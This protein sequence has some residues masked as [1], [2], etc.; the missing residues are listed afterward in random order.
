MARKTS[1]GKFI[2]S[3]AEVGSF[4]MCPE[5]WRLRAIERKK[6][7]QDSGITDGEKLHAEW[8]R[9]HDEVVFLSQGI[10]L[11]IFLILVLLLW[12]HLR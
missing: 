8:A 5:S 6:Q 10:R 1:Y 3:A 2:V 7:L 12:S 9:G 11:I 4:T